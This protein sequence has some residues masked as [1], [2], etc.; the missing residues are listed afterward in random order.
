MASEMQFENITRKSNDYLNDANK[1]LAKFLVAKKKVHDALLN[2]NSAFKNSLQV[3]Q[4]ATQIGDIFKNIDGL[5]AEIASEPQYAVFVRNYINNLVYHSL[6]LSEMVTKIALTGG[7]NNILMNYQQRDEL[8]RDVSVRLSLINA[9]LS[10]MREH[11]YF[12]KADG[13]WKS[14]NPFKDWIGQ[15]RRIVG[16]IIRRSKYLGL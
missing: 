6:A 3:K 11:I 10:L 4:I 12:A 2:V 14:I 7:E 9:N 15:D 13:F 1:N 5:R 16:D 8:L